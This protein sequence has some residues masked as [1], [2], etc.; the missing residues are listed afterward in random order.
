MG[1]VEKTDDGILLKNEKDHLTYGIVADTVDLK[2]GERVELSGRKYK[3]R[4]GKLNVDVDT[5]VEDY[6]P[7]PK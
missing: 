6:G 5:L 1:C 7:C 3:D 2:D 4:N